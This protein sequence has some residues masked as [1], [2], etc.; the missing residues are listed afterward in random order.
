ML[1][2]HNKQQTFVHA[3]FL[4]CTL[5][6]GVKGVFPLSKVLKNKT[7][8]PGFTPC[9]RKMWV[10]KFIGR[11]FFFLPIMSGKVGQSLDLVGV[12][13]KYL[14]QWKHPLSKHIFFI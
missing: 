2:E 3:L 10:R 8:D 12:F 14:A 4:Q 1:R 5:K 9:S 13:F 6:S 7:Q 11:L